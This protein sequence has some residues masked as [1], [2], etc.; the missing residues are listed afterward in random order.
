MRNFYLLMALT[1]FSAQASAEW[2][3]ISN[4]DDEINKYMDK[5]T[6]WNQGAY[7]AM[8]DMTDFKTEQQTAERIKYLS[9]KSLYLYNCQERTLGVKSIVYYGKNMGV[10]NPVHSFSIQPPEVTFQDAIPSSIGATLLKVACA[11]K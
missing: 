7:V 8:W 10:G 11:K 3:L 1:L 5:S 2:E 4:N 6:I 9:K